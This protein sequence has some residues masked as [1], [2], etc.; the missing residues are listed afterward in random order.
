MASPSALVFFM[1]LLRAVVSSSSFNLASSAGTWKVSF[2]PPPHSGLSVTFLVVPVPES[3]FP[4][5]TTQK[6]SLFPS[7]SAFARPLAL[8]IRSVHCSI[9]SVSS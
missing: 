4:H 7:R 9:L 5:F 6:G 1:V 8:M 3:C 2:S